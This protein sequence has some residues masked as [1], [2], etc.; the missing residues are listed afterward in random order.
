MTDQALVIA[1]P[2][3]RILGEALPII[4]AAGIV[5]EPAFGDEDSRALQD[6]NRRLRVEQIA[7]AGHGLPFDQP[8]RLAHAIASFIHALDAPVA[9]GKLPPA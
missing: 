1:V 8:E 7:G 3:G 5:P 9:V 2:K 6:L 4:T